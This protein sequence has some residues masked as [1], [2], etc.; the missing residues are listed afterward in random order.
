MKIEMK[1]FST[2]LFSLLLSS[3]L[4]A[5]ELDN[6]GEKVVLKMVETADVHGNFFS[7]DYYNNCELPGGL[8]RVSSFMRE[9][10]ASH[11]ADGCILL[12]NG[13]YLQGQPCVYYGNFIDTQSPIHLGADV[14]NYMNYD[15]ANI[16]NHD[17]EAGHDVYDRWIEDCNCDVLSGNMIST[18]SSLPYA[19]PYT[20]IERRGVKIAV[21]GLL[22]SGI[23]VWLPEKLWSG[24]H[25]AGNKEYAKLWSEFII[26]NEKPDLLIGLFHQGVDGTVEGEQYADF[27]CRQIAQSV[28]GFD[29]IFMGHDHKPHNEVVTNSVDGKEVLL[30]N[31]GG[32]TTSVAVATLECTLEGGRFS[33]VEIAGELIS[34]EGYESDPQMMAHFGDVHQRV[35]DFTNERVGSL[36][37]PINALDYYFGNSDMGNLF[38]KTQFNITGA[39]ISLAAPLCVNDVIEAGDI[40][41]YDVFKLYRYENMVN[42][43]LLTG[44]E[45][46]G[47]LEKGYSYLVAQ[48]QDE[49]D[50]FIKMMQGND[51]EYRLG[52]YNSNM[53][54]AAGIIYEVDV[55][56]PHGEMITII[57]MSS[58]EPYDMDKQYRVAINSYLGCGSGDLLTEGAGIEHA[59]LAKR[60]IATSDL[61]FRY[62]IAD[63]MKEIDETG[64]IEPMSNWK[65]VPEKFV[66]KAIKRDYKRL[67]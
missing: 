24:T 44:R 62:H 49:N 36:K 38:H 17:V 28:P 4:L 67:E 22:T 47:A 10:R 40:Y 46:K 14:L 16:G 39:D 18:E 23:P 32:N 2:L 53:I 26:K 63:T 52:Y 5:G 66:K 12:E 41:M 25:F 43:M 15:V 64:V 56:K 11:G 21:L 55:T 37:R 29:I 6:S 20:I 3:T 9:L 51:G 65:Y 8:T 34:V 54:T 33:S 50:E 60:I 19:K 7:Y 48:M 61:D 57:S 35:Q 30:I 31:P 42:T 59:D 45:V 58:G 27:S 13:D 1:R